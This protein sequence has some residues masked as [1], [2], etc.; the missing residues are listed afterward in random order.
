MAAIGPKIPIRRGTPK[1]NGLKFPLRVLQTV[2]VLNIKL[3]WTLHNM[4]CF[5]NIYLHQACH[6]RFSDL[7]LELGHKLAVDTYK[8]CC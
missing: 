6:E 1:L 2:S 4:L 7:K 3:K 8:I 5:E